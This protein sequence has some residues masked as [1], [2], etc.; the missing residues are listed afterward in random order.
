MELF[1]SSEGP[2]LVCDPLMH[3][4]NPGSKLQKATHSKGKG[5]YHKQEIRLTMFTSGNRKYT[6]HPQ[7]KSIT[8]VV[9]FDCGHPGGLGLGCFRAVLFYYQ[10][11]TGS[12]GV[13]L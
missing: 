3:R 6:P 11:P 4:D 13:I 8:L 9:N 12:P 7:P 2:P 1:L 10:L 5:K